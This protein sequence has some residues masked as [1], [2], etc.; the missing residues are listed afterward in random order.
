MANRILTMEI[1]NSIIKICE[2]EYKAKKP[3]V[4]QCFHVATPPGI[5]ED[6]V[7]E[8]NEE[9][10]TI[11]TNVLHQKKMKTKKVVFTVSSTKIANREIDV[12]ATKKES[13]Y[14]GIVASSAQDYFPVDLSQ[15]ILSHK[16]LHKFESQDGEKAHLQVYAAPGFLIKSYENLATA[17]G[18]TCVGIDVVGNS[19]KNIFSDEF[20]Q[21]VHLVIKIDDNACLLTV[22][23]NNQITFQRSILNGVDDAVHMLQEESDYA[24]KLPYGEAVK[25]FRMEP[26]LQSRLSPQSDFSDELSVSRSMGNEEITMALQDMIGGITRII[27]F[28]HAQ[29]SQMPIMDIFLTGIGAEFIGMKELLSN[30]LQ[31]NTMVL[32][33][34]QNIKLDNKIANTSIGAYAACIG[35]G[36]SPMFEISKKKKDASQNL[37]AASFTRMGALAGGG[38]LLV[39]GVLAATAILPYMKA[40]EERNLQKMRYER[41]IETEQMFAEYESIERGYNEMMKMKQFL[42]SSNSMLYRIFCD[43]EDAMPSGV[44]FESLEA[45]G[46]TV[47]INAKCGSVEQMANAL[48]SIRKMKE[49][50]SIYCDGYRVGKS[51]ATDEMTVMFTMECT[52]IRESDL[53]PDM[54]GEQPLVGPDIPLEKKIKKSNEPIRLDPDQVEIPSLELNDEKETQDGEETTEDETGETE[55]SGD[56]KQKSNTKE[57]GNE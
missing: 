12:M 29:N 39:S 4:Y 6:G 54:N 42:N 36:F 11:I 13:L 43:L 8:N 34:S 33:R 15:Y 23:N 16:V 26:I 46:Y 49:F 25:R 3:V 53:V 44:T 30:E 21:G 50:Q 7:V 41:M 55:D 40:V 57:A 32:Q 35:A 20:S 22:F 27:D 19:I 47:T 45:D 52:Y 38:L 2:M 31:K 56:S 10:I 18:L 24:E 48:Q 17:C 14:A 1:G 9:L 5:I 51:D 37:D 28:Y